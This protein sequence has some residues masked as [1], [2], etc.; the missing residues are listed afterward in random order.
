MEPEPVKWGSAQE[1]YTRLCMVMLFH[2]A[3]YYKHAKQ[4]IFDHEYDLMERYLIHVGKQPGVERHPED[5]AYTVGCPHSLPRTVKLWVDRFLKDGS[6]PFGHR[7]EFGDDWK[8]HLNSIP[9]VH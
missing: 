5:P 6:I 4:A 1:Q 2:K 7:L 3:L 9:N 8:N